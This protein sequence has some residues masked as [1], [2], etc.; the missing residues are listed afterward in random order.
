[1]EHKGYWQ[2]IKFTR[3]KESRPYVT[4]QGCRFYVDQF[5]NWCGASEHYTYSIG[6]AVYILEVDSRGEK[7]RVTMCY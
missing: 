5:T 7:A 4:Y 2:G 6:L 1:M 3:G